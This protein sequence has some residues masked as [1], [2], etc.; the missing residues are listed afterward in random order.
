M[1]LDIYALYKFT[2]FTLLN[3]NSKQF[4]WALK[5]DFFRI[6]NKNSLY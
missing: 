5:R 1:A 4:C 6:Y 2:A 3:K